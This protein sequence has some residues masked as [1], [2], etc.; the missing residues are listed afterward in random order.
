MAQALDFA[1]RLR[2]PRR[3]PPLELRKLIAQTMDRFGLRE[4]ADGRIAQLPGASGSWS[5]SRSNCSRSPRSS[6]STSRP[7]ASIRPRNTGSWKCCAKSPTAAAPSSARSMRPKACTSWTSSRSIAG[8]QRHL[9]RNAGGSSRLFRD[10]ASSRCC[11][12]ASVKRRRG[13]GSPSH[14]QPLRRLWRRSLPAP[15]CYNA[16]RPY[17]PG[18]RFSWA[19][20]GRFCSRLAQRRVARPSADPARRPNW[21][22]SR[23]IPPHR[24]FFAWAAALWFGCTNAAP[25]IVRER[26]IYQRERFAGVTPEL[27]VLGKLLFLGAVT[28]PPIAALLRDSQGM[29]RTWGLHRVAARRPA[30][31]AQPPASPSAASFPPWRAI[32]CRLSSPSHSSHPVHP[33]FGRAA[34]RVADAPGPV[35]A[36]AASITPSFAAQRCMDLSFLSPAGASPYAHAL[37]TLLLWTGGAAAATCVTLR[38]RE[39]C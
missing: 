12:I 33:S 29:L 18:S 37:I 22:G 17:F 4:S 35:A 39:K 11:R 10:R 25:G 15:R 20:N 14:R 34:R 26:P 23:A 36:V 21:M 19:A 6:S 27:Y 16:L 1:A 5:A 31:Y 8:G 24:L 2:F 9:H 30:A 13:N 3:T 28:C 38:L 32:P 7:P